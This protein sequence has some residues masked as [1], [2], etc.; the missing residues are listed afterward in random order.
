MRTNLGSLEDPVNFWVELIL[1]ATDEGLQF[2]FFLL[3]DAIT[4][5]KT[6]GLA[7]LQEHFS[8]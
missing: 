5:K 7:I 4:G 2:V 1:I 8:T 6:R 3:A